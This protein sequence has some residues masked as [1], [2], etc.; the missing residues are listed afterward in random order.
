MVSLTSGQNLTP[1]YQLVRR[2]GENGTAQVWLVRDLELGHDAVAK[3]LT[4]DAPASSLELLK[5][6][7]LVARKLAHPSVVRMYDFARGDGFTFF[8]MAHVDGVSLSLYEGRPFEELLPLLVPIA[9]ALDHAH[10]QGV[11]HR[12]V[13]PSN[14]LVDSRGVP[15]LGDFGAAGLL[16]QAD[17]AGGGTPGY[18][19]PEQ[20]AGAPTS[21]GDDVYAFGALVLKLVTGEPAH[22]T[23]PDSVPARLRPLLVSLLS[24]DPARRP[25]SMAAV[26]KE[27]EALRDRKEPPSLKPPQRV[28]EI[29]PRSPAR[30]ESPGGLGCKT[31][32]AFL[33][34]GGAAAF[35][36]AFLP[37][38]VEERRTTPVPP[39]AL[40]PASP[41]EPE[42]PADLRDLA[43]EKT[44]A[45]RIREDVRR[46]KEALDSRSAIDWGGADY[47]EGV[48]RLAAGESSLLVR[49]YAKAASELEEAKRL[50]E[51][52]AAKGATLA[53]EAV[54]NGERALQAGRSEEAREQFTFALAVDGESTRARKGLARAASLD[55]VLGLVADGESRERRGDLGGA[56]ASY[57]RAASLDPLVSAAQEGLARVDAAASESAF[58]AAMSE[59]VAA[60]GRGAYEEARTALEQAKAMRP[61]APEVED[62]LAQ[63]RDGLLARDI[64]ARTRLAQDRETKEDW[65][66]AEKEYD[67]V[68]ALDPTIRVAQDGKTRTAGRA[69][70]QEKLDFQIGHADRLSDGNALREASI[71]L[72]EAREVHDAGP[73]HRERVAKLEELVQAYAVPV[74]LKLV[75][76]E[77]TDVTLTRVGRLGKFDERTLEL[78]PGRYTVVGSRDGYRD[79]RR[80]I[81]IAPGKSVGVVIVIRCEEK[82]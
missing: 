19:S 18:A 13:K 12:D 28:P 17:V 67:A 46:Q 49:E 81:E 8:T 73:K 26:K 47:R 15:H 58:Q 79:V 66:G 24:T 11:V 61:G 2:F 65:R 59:A 52:V 63:V 4:D 44:S 53:A 72:E 3:I 7:F 75:S 41:A 27:L 74:T 23:L 1:R 37:R 20:L 62:G 39:A 6:E 29:S 64:A 43:Q 5:R 77:L 69:L 25:S 38:F 51:A 80:E 14:V 50:F 71:L 36:F 40:E 45:E 35:V 34:L 42:E 9:D 48:A 76:D 22:G 31:V 82:I 16:S 30:E 55:Q 10:R 70:L 60:L 57:R 21:V 32:A 33:V 78:R 56:A 54:E 68:L